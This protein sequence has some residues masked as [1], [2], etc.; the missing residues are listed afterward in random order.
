MVE[1]IAQEVDIAALEPGVGEHLAYRSAQA[2]VIVGDDIFDT[3][4]AA[5]LEPD[6]KVRP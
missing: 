4:Q 6:Q 1:R 2:G 3:V 5:G